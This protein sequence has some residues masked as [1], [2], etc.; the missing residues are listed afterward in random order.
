[1]KIEEKRS[2][3]KLI[4]D[5]YY[6]NVDPIE[7][8]NATGLENY[9]DELYPDDEKK[10]VGDWISQRFNVKNFLKLEE[11]TIEFNELR[12]L[13]LKTRFYCNIPTGETLNKLMT[14]LEEWKK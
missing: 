12:D 2:L 1:M 4:Y 14:E 3:Q 5:I 13:F 8:Y 9:M 10:L 6:N 11:L 7:F